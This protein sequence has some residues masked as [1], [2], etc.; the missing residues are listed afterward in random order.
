MP[1]APT[2]G[3]LEKLTVRAYT[4]PD[5]S[6]S[7]V[8]EF[9]VFFNPEEYTQVYDV[10]YDGTQGQGTTGS[11]VVFRR[12]KPQE[13]TFKLL[14]DGTGTAG[15]KIDVY[16]RIRDFF[17]TVG[18]DGQIHRPRFLKLNWGTLESRCVLSK[19]EVTY[20]MFQPDGSP[21]RA[22]LTATF[23]ENIDDASR[24]ARARDSSPDLTHVRTVREGDTL[25]LLVY[26]VYKDISYY[27]AVAAFNELDNFRDLK[28]GTKLVFPP[29]AKE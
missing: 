4:A 19:A 28:A 29:L 7:P 8:A 14:F 5:Y 13:Y 11:P 16:E 3:E 23:T 20:K 1:S 27:P 12:I 17:S 6:G 15:E 18:Y 25:P 21:I 9:K 26:E 22:L 2:R 24:V 10:E